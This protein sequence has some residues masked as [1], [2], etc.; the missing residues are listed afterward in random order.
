MRKNRKEIEFTFPVQY[1]AYGCAFFNDPIPERGFKG[2]QK[3]M[4]TLNAANTVI[5]C[6]HPS[7]IGFAGGV[8]WSANSPYIDYVRAWGSVPRMK[9][10]IEEHIAPLI[11]IAHTVGMRV[12]YLISGWDCAKKYPQYR[13]IAGRVPET[14]SKLPLSVYRDWEKE[15]N[16]EWNGPGY[17]GG[18]KDVQSVLDIAPPIAPQP[19]DWVVTTTA[20][21]TTLLHE[22]GIW[23]IL[24]T[25]FA[26][27]GCLVWSEGG[28]LAMRALGYRKIV[29]RDCTLHGETAETSPNM[30]LTR[31]ALLMIERS[32]LAYTA[33]GR[34][35][36][37]AIE[38]AKITKIK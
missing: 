24:Y 35:V 18:A 13:E 7:N 23:N 3:K 10:I 8:P 28:L 20:Q 19:Q 27:G 37:S 17:S 33:S 32:G 36:Q 22:N 11:E 4:L 21:A 15:Y 31:S 38:S 6:M 34:D 5:A 26:T 2:L 14:I 1:F 9:K 29:L 25:G 30:E 16:E 12:I